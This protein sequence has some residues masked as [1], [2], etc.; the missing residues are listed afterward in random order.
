MSQFYWL[1][2]KKFKWFIISW[3]RDHEDPNFFMKY[4]HGFDI[5]FRAYRIVFEWI[6]FNED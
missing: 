4:R 2:E 3:G 5:T 1:K 6:G